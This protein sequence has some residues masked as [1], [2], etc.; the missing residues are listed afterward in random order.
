LRGHEEQRLAIEAALDGQSV[1]QRQE[2]L[3]FHH[4]EESWPDCPVRFASTATKKQH[5]RFFGGCVKRK[6]AMMSEGTL[7]LSTSGE[8]R[9][10]RN[11]RGPAPTA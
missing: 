6:R 2:A 7:P 8:E 11:L 5:E 1:S 4:L 10:H 9:S 3:A